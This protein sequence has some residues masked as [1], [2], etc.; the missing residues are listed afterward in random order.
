[1]TEMNANTEP[2]RHITPEAFAMLGLPNVAYVKRVVSEGETSY[3]IRAAN[4]DR[5]GV[6]P[7]HDVAVAAII[8]HEMEPVYL[9]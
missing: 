8:E 7:S 6:A 3:E 1:M 5:I 2:L 4:G 9:H